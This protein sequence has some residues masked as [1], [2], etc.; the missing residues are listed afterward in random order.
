VF[1]ELYSLSHE[2]QTKDDIRCLTEKERYPCIDCFAFVF[3]KKGE[4]KLCPSRSKRFKY[5]QI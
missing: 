3:C 5:F 4:L 1:D 2:C